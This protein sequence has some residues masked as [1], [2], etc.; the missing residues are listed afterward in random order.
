MFTIPYNTTLFV[1]GAIVFGCVGF[2]IYDLIKGFDKISKEEYMNSEQNQPGTV[3]QRSS[4]S[5]GSAGRRLSRKE[6]LA[7]MEGLK[8]GESIR[9]SIPETFGGGFAQIQ[10]NPGPGKKWILKVSKS[11]NGLDESRPYWAHDK[12]KP[13]ATWVNDRLGALLNPTMDNSR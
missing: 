9:F 11:L 5:V 2:V 10:P 13:I 1:V 3:E 6:I 4:S 12:A 8:E 7:L